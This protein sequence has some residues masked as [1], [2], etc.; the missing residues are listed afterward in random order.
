MAADLHIREDACRPAI[1]QLPVG[2][3][4]VTQSEPVGPFALGLLDSGAHIRCRA[5]ELRRIHAR[6]LQHP[7][8]SLVDRSLV[9][10]PG[11]G[12]AQWNNHSTG[13]IGVTVVLHIQIAHH[14]PGFGVN[15]M[16]MIAL[17]ESFYADLPVG[18]PFAAHVPHHPHLVDLV[19]LKVSLGQ[20]NGRL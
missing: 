18:S 11:A 15:G 5:I 9:C 13:A 7:L 8:Q 3:A 16:Q 12:L 6:F 20:A 1:G 2:K 17:V 14:A 4:F 10:L 19:V